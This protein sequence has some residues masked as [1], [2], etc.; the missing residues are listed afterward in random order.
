MAINEKNKL[1]L[2]KKWDDAKAELLGTYSK[3][4]DKKSIHYTKGLK[5]L[6]DKLR[7]SLITNNYR[8]A[9]K[10]YYIEFRKWLRSEVKE[11]EEKNRP[12]FA[13]MSKK[14]ITNLVCLSADIPT[15]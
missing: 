6:T 2:K 4:K 7:D 14:E 15:Q 3:Q 11:G 9:R 13:F 1:I 10:T 5:Q 12:I 8:K